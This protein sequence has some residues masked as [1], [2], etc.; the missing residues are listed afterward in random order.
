MEIDPGKWEENLAQGKS[1]GAW[2]Q[3]LSR[4]RLRAAELMY[5]S[6]DKGYALLS[7]TERAITLDTQD[8]ARHRLLDLCYIS[9]S[10]YGQE[11]SF[12]YYFTLVTPI[13]VYAVLYACIHAL[14]CINVC[15]HNIH[16]CMNVCIWMCNRYAEL[17][18]SI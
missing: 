8:R 17:Y 9:R 11:Y 3:R 18:V 1:Y 14:K 5:G 10:L 13:C 2:V 7:R 6:R 12:G 15:M 16:V 4:I